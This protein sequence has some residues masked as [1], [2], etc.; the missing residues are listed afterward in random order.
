MWSIA[1]AQAEARR[2]QTLIDQ[3]HD[4]RQVKADAISAK[5]DQAAALAKKQISESVTVADVWQVY[6]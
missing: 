5:E 4:P 1:D 2:L 6:V 3:G